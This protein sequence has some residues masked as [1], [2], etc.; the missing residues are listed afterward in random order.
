MHKKA[1]VTHAYQST[2]WT[3]SPT[4]SDILPISPYKQLL[5]AK[6]LDVSTSRQETIDVGDLKKTA[7]LTSAINVFIQN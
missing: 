3:K 5:Q 6:M 4:S 2:V 1:S 7:L